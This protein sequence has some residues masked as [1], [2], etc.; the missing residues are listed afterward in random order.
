MITTRFPADAHS[1]FKLENDYDSFQ[2]RLHVSALDLR[3]QQA[4]DRFV[5]HFE[6]QFDRLDIL[7]HN[8]AQTLRRPREFFQHVAFW[9]NETRRLQPRSHSHTRECQ[10]LTSRCRQ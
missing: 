10:Q 7:I 2:A 6:E 9:D 8:A 3:Y 1:R 5:E 4:I